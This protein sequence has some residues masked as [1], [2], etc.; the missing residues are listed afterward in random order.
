MITT[1]KISNVKVSNGMLECPLCGSK[2]SEACLRRH[3]MD[4]DF[5]SIIWKKYQQ[6]TNGI[7]PS[8]LVGG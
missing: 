5:V 2:V 4:P 8:P 6:R 7:T 3:D 1:V